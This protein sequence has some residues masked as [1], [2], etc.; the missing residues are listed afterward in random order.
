MLYRL[1]AIALAAFMWG[2]STAPANDL[3]DSLVEGRSPVVVQAAGELPWETNDVAPLLVTPSDVVE[4]LPIDAGE[5]ESVRAPVVETRPRPADS[6]TAGAELLGRKLAAVTI[7][8]APSP[9]V[10]TQSERIK[11]E[12]R[13]RDRA[14]ERFDEA[15]LY[16]TA[17]SLG[18]DAC[19][20]GF[21][22][23]APSLYHRALLLEEPNLERYGHQVAVCS[24]DNLTQSLISGAHF[25]GTVPVLPYLVGAYGCCEPQYV[26]GLYRP[27]SCNPHRL[28]KPRDSWRGVAVQAAASTGLVVFVP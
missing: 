16:V 13:I 20:W 26:L 25:F 15:G 14:A 19:G 11:S 12:N 2:A 6:A 17:A 8:A 23:A 21:A 1:L 3:Y 22:W 18:P 9:R 4:P 24:K 27:G 7:D 10:A 5:P 28:V